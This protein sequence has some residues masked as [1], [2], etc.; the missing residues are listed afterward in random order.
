MVLSEEGIYV[1]RFNGHDTK[2]C[3]KVS[4][5]CRTISY[6]IQQL[7]TGLYIYLDGTDT[8]KTPYDCPSSDPRYPGIA[9]TRS[10]SFVSIK[11]RAHISCLRGIPWLAYGTKRKHGI[12]ISF[13]GLT[14]LNTSVQ[15][16]DAFMTVDD[17]VF[18]EAKLVSLD[19]RVEKLPRFDLSLNNV[20]FE[21]NIACVR[22]YTKT[23]KVFVNIT[24]TIFYQNGNPSSNIPSILWLA[25]SNTSINIQVRNCSFEKNTFKEYGMFSVINVLGATNVLLKQLRLEE[26]RQIYPSVKNYNG[27]FRFKSKQLFL[28][29]EYGF[30]YKTSGTFLYVKNGLSAEINISN[31]EVDEFYSGSAGGGVVNVMKLDSCYLSIKDSSFRNGNNYHYGGILLIAAKNATLTIQNSTIHNIFSSNTGGAVY[32]QSNPKDYRQSTNPNKNFVVFLRI[33]NSS[34][35]NSSSG[36]LAGALYVF[37]QRLSAI[38]QGSLFLQCNARTSGGTLFLNATD[39][40]T[41]L[42]HNSYFLKNSVQDREIVHMLFIGIRNDSSFNV[43]ITNVAF[44]ENRLRPQQRNYGV[45]HFAALRTK[46]TVDIKKTYFINNFAGRGSTI[47]IECVGQ[48]RLCFVRFHNCIFRNN[49]GNFGT[50]AVEGLTSIT[51]KHSIFDSNGCV[52]CKTDAAT[53]MI[54]SNDS[55]I[56]IMNTTFVNNFCQ[57]IFAKLGGISTL[58][59]S[60]NISGYQQKS[61]RQ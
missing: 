44:S 34:F 24:N 19:I 9:L 48:S 38:I 10:A 54:Y 32:I 40:A 1:S 42:L 41:I 26:N 50:V 27:L 23:R 39:S 16:S 43:S 47:F 36:D 37:A 28:R 14:F 52:S 2:T 59:R 31:V 45:V 30:I 21:K 7:S 20:V 58:S 29:L 61:T 56:F 15:L 12:R 49:V 53:F 46:I 51:C 60:L 33:I 18:A 5:P 35:S 55:M 25:S 4:S 22:I 13:T 11:S 8:L 3:G 6:G 17:T 57:T